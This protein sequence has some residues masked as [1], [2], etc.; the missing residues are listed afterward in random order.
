MLEFFTYVVFFVLMFGCLHYIMSSL[1]TEEVP[2]DRG[3]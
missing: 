3:P 1:E 2:R